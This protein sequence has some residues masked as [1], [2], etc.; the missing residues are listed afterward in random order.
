MERIVIVAYKPF[1]D[2]ESELEK[3]IETHWDI[4]NNEGLVSNRKSIIMKAKNGTII[5][6]FGWQSKDAMESA[7]SNETVQNMWAEYS[8]VCEYIP[9]SEVQESQQLFSEFTPV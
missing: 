9:I 8:K 5:E 1:L 3:L 7:H 6:I 4:L 2:K